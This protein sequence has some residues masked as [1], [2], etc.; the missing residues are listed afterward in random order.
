MRSPE[1]NGPAGRPVIGWAAIALGVLGL[2]H[3]EH[4]L[5][6]PNGGQE[7]MR[8]AGGA[9][10]YIGSALIADLFRST[11]DRRPAARAADVL[12]SARRHRDA[13][14]PDPRSG[15]AALRDKVLGRTPVDPDAEP[16]PEPAG[17]RAAAA[18]P[19][20]PPRRRA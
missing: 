9:V 4:G 12:R 8:E 16:A 13:R 3:I 10:G 1:L 5:P 17:A 11:R 2:I 7:A 19:A 14:L 18:Q 15:S 20:A 6:R